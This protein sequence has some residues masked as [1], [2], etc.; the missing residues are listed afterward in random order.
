[1]SAVTVDST[2]LAGYPSTVTAVGGPASV[3]GW[4]A[5]ASASAS[6]P[7]PGVGWTRVWSVHGSTKV[8]LIGHTASNAPGSVPRP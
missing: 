5:S 1:M 4:L 7:G 2:S 8:P 3:P 6:M